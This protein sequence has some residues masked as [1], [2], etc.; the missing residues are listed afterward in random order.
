MLHHVGTLIALIGPPR[1]TSLHSFGAL[2]VSVGHCSEPPLYCS[3]SWPAI[4]AESGPRDTSGNS[5]GRPLRLEDQARAT[6]S[7][8]LAPFWNVASPPS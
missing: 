3:A 5:Y 6:S 1:A 4:A 7:W 8:S 2:L